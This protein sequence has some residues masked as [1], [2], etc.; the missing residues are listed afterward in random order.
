MQKQLTVS[1]EVGKI[2]AVIL[3]RWILGMAFSVPLTTIP[4]SLVMNGR[5]R[6]FYI[7]VTDR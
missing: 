1:V 6:L 7:I 2:Y 3:H 4:A 5:I